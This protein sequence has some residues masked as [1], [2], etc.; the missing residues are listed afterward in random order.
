MNV[1]SKEDG[2]KTNYCALCSHYYV[3]DMRPRGGGLA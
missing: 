1:Y 2:N 3:R